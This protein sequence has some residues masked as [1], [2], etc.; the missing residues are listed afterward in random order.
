M[1]YVFPAIIPF[2]SKSILSLAAYKDFLTLWQTTHVMAPTSRA[3]QGDA[4]LARSAVGLRLAQH[5]AHI[6]HADKAGCD[7][8]TI[9]R[10]A[11]HAAS[12]SHRGMCIRLRN[13]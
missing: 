7:A 4:R 6:L 5:L 10:L 12:R 3:V 1:S 13:G 2:A 9:Q 11:G 8:F